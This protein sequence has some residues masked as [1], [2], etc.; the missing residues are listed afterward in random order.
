MGHVEELRSRFDDAYEAF[1]DFQATALSRLYGRGEPVDEACL[2]VM[3]GHGKNVR[4]LFCLLTAKAMIAD[5]RSALP[6]ALAVE[7]VHTYSLV[8]DDLPSRDDGELRRGRPTAHVKFDEARAL[9]CGDALLTAAFKVLADQEFYPY[10]FEATAA[11]RCAQLLA[12]AAGGRG[13]VAAQALDMKYTGFS[14]K[15]SLEILESIHV[16]KTGKLLGAACAM[17]AASTGASDTQIDLMQ[18]FGEL[19]GLAFQIKDDLLDDTAY[20]GKSAGKDK[21][22]GKLTYLEFFD[23]GQCE[24]KISDLT[25]QALNKAVLAGADHKELIDLVMW[26]YKRDC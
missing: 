9:L 8:H 14:Q 22:S 4:P 25:E 26:L 19:I 16:H 1:D 10:H 5:F 21:A 13:L 6:A 2:Y 15:P 20:T 17:G 7:M 11:L 23:A 24:E 18:S 3:G 12:D